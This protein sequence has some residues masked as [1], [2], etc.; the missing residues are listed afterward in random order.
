MRL[1]LLR[2][3]RTAWNEA[4]R[5]QG[6][7]DIPLSPFGRR[8]VAAWRLPPPFA[9]ASC[10]ASPLLRARETAA[11]LGHTDHTLDHRLQEMSWG[12]YEGC[13]LAELR[14]EHGTRFAAN[15]ARGLDFR[16]PGGESPREVA[17][18]LRACLADLA[19]TRRDHLI[20]THKGVL[21]VS[22]VL[23]LGWTMLREPPVA[24]ADDQALLY[25]VGGSGS[26]DFEGAIT[27]A[28][29]GR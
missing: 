1:C 19:R 15:T 17:E 14:R 9:R 5:I 4:G 21:R 8:Q 10:I 7:T 24:I 28:V 18:R 16:P 2:H 13:T 23:A 29:A 27:L 25:R 26:L 22:L 6:R 3:G 20:V 11:I 12:A